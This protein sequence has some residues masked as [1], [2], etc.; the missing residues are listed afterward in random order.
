MSDALA[1]MDLALPRAFAHSRRMAQEREVDSAVT[2]MAAHLSVAATG[3]RSRKARLI[4]EA[5]AARART[6]ADLAADALAERRMEVALALRSGGMSNADMVDALAVAGEYARRTI[7]LEPYSQQMAC[8]AALIGGC[9]AEMDTGEGKTIAAFLAAAVFGLA[10]R[11][12]HVVTSNDYLAGRDAEQVRPALE[13]LG[14]TVG[15]VTGDIPVSPRR[16]AYAADIAYVSS[17]E[18]CFDYLRDGLADTFITGRSALASKLGRLL[19]AAARDDAEPLQRALD[20]A[21]IDEIDSV[22]IDEATTP[23][24]IS[25]NT[26]GD[27]SEATA[28]QA[29]ELAAGLERGIDFTV[30]PHGLMPTL[31]LRGERRLEQEV[32]ELTGPWRVRLIRNELLRAATAAVHTLRRDHHYLVRDGKIVLIDQQNGRTMPDRYLN[33]SLSLM[34]EV[35]EGCAISGERKSLASISFQRFFR[36]YATICGLSGTVREVAVELHTVYG[37]RMTRIARRLPL[38]R[39]AAPP[40]VFS[41]RTQLWSRAADKA[42]ALQA[43]GQPVLVAVRTVTE[44]KRASEALHERGVIHR[45]LSAAQDEAEA[46]IIAGAGARGT[47]TVVTNMAGRGTD[48]RLEAGVAELGGLVV[49]MCERNESRRVDRQLMG[50]CARQGDPG[51]VAEFISQRDAILQMLG[52]PWSKILRAWPRITS[53]AITRAQSIC[54][55]RGRHDRLQLLRRDRQLAKVMAFAGGLD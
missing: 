3:L 45:V 47:V 19:G 51:L 24:L 34:V 10:G 43:R 6:L 27:I 55:R 46:D 4:G 50:R 16:A 1:T 28:R 39:D 37:L 36:N 20:V 35:K 9:V 21:I 7:G 48:I 40:I 41:D 33:H 8:A 53:H 22:L 49:L 18:V 14:L 54:E 17:K 38:R 31:T 15:V 42:Q 30:D 5:A 32:A 29:L 13:A 52:P 12:V 26:K 11:C 25:T 23:L 44:A 2:W